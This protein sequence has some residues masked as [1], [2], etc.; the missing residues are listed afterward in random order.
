MK[1]G[2]SCGA[3]ALALSIAFSVLP[4]GPAAA[5]D[6]VS[7]TGTLVKNDT[8]G[9]EKAWGRELVLERDGAIIRVM[10]GTYGFSILDANGRV[11]EEFLFPEDAVGFQLAA[12]EYELRP[13]ACRI[14]RHH[15]VE[16]TVEY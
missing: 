6:R 14:H 10:D 1:S 9:T 5:G 11:V 8:F 7:A 15:H 12:G 16:V 13:F 3:A 4:A 2:I